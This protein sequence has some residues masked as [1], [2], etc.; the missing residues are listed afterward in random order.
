LPT[1]I[2]PRASVVVPAYNAAATLPAC[3]AALAH[4]TVSSTEFEVIVVDDGS[5]DDTAAL[6]RAAGVQVIRQAHAGPAA[7]RNRG[8]A[9][10][11][12]D[13]VFFTDAD[14][15]P[16][17]GWIT[18]LIGA[19]D[20]PLVAGAKGAYLTRQREVVPRFTQL[21]FLERYDRMAGAETIDFVDTYS[22]AYRRSVF[23]ANNGFDTIFPTASVEDQEFSFRLAEK[24]Y[25]LVFVPTAQVYHRHNPTL[26]AYVRR[27][28]LI[29][30]WKSLLAHWHPGRIVSDS[31]T[32]GTLKLQIVLVGAMLG[33]AAISVVTNLIIGSLWWPGF[34]VLGIAA[35]IFLLTT[36]SFLAK[37]WV[38]DRGLL[39]PAVGLLWIRALSLGAG[40]A[41]GLIR[42]RHKVGERRPAI[43]GPQ[44][45]VKR[46]VDLT[47]AAGGLLLAALPMAA[48]ALIVKIDSPGPAIFT[49]LRVGQNG[50]PFRIFKFRTMVVHAERLLPQF[51]DLDA[52]PQPA[53]KLRDDP[54]VTPAGRFLRRYSLD[55]LPQLVNVLRGEMSLIGPRPEE[56]ALVERYSDT[57][58]R[59]LSVKPGMTGP[60]QVNGRGNLTFEQRLILELDYIDHYSLRRDLVILMRTV[61]AIVRGDGAY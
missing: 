1:E 29:G 11:S 5:T 17:P 18:E 21:E 39:L 59:R 55:E 32:P 10:A 53:F 49:Q 47:I 7:A 43:S 60:M 8:A 20:D 25:R 30:Y 34:A 48:I 40:F 2:E 13:L 16:V 14:C 23:L 37:V 45:V 50:R 52:L 12:G 36:A 41:A 27:K 35:L 54:R 4:Q 51:V 42:F 24:G 38:R 19:F 3:L 26:H 31:Y 9:A 44:R 61:P 46:L 28:F 56:A 22:A 6:A 57:Q 58:R 15:A 33:A